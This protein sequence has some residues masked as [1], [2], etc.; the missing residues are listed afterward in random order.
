[1]ICFSKRSSRSHLGSAVINESDVIKRSG[2]FLKTH[3]FLRSRLFILAQSFVLVASSTPSFGWAQVPKL[4]A[5]D[6][7]AKLNLNEDFLLQP[8]GLDKFFPGAE[9][10]QRK[11]G[12]ISPLN[13]AYCNS[14]ALE[15]RACFQ[16]LKVLI[17]SGNASASLTLLPNSL[18]LDPLF[19]V[20]KVRANYAP[21]SLVEIGRA[22]S[23]KNMF[24]SFK[25]FQRQVQR[26]DQ[27]VLEVF[28]DLQAKKAVWSFYSLYKNLE[29]EIQPPT[30]KAFAATNALNAFLSV[31]L[32]PHTEY[33][34]ATV[35]DDQQKKVAQGENFFGIGAVLTLSK[36]QVFI[37]SVMKNS[38][39]ARAQ[40]YAGDEIV[41]INQAPLTNL[42]LEE[43]VSLI[44][45]PEN[46]VVELE[47][48]RGGLPVSKS[49]L[50]G[51]VSVKNLE[52]DQISLPRTKGST[53][54]IKL[55]SFMDPSSCG[56]IQKLV[57]DAEAQSASGLIFDV[58]NNGGGLV[59]LAICISS[60]FIG[61]H[62]VFIEESLPEKKRKSHRNPR[63]ILAS[64]L[65]LVLLQNAG[66]ASASELMAGALQDHQRAWILGEQSFG[67]G[68]VQAVIPPS[69]IFP[70]LMFKV[71]IARFLQPS[72][73]TN[74]LVGIT[75]DFEVP[76]KPQ[77]TPEERF[78]LREG[79]IYPTA[80]AAQ[81]PAWSSPRPKQRAEMEACMLSKGSADQQYQSEWANP[82]KQQTPDYQL[83]KAL[84]LMDCMIAP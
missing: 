54:Y 11:V 59:N 82:Q 52:S 81:G 37:Q 41:K 61:N 14:G 43:V 3:G 25:D 70:G 29:S 20:T 15:F 26:L 53:S 79:D 30:R 40:L 17:E 12:E 13:D 46:S 32:D 73:R 6:E 8:P 78:S 63:P 42:S 2:V 75:P 50:R 34:S 57:A 80:L 69:E 47:I 62:V 68:S 18:S 33:F 45:G 16:A 64:R 38:P 76:A 21:W 58:R 39:A 28:K 5:I 31:L 65:P 84:D 72:G 83:L 10:I 36:N 60:I 66:S 24:E 71:T 9:V 23:Q 22:P 19:Q 4:N 51:K 77:M 27:A 48:L 67:K 44:R 7:L 74:Q 56:P 1:M 49:I 55:N 35:Y